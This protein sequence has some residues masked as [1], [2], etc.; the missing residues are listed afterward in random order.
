MLTVSAQ[1]DIDLSPLRST[2]AHFFNSRITFAHDWQYAVQ[3]ALY[4]R[5]PFWRQRSGPFTTERQVCI[6][7]SQ[8]NRFPVL[9]EVL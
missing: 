9:T 8:L 3:A 1:K 7:Q 6:Q 4:P 5:T 2:G